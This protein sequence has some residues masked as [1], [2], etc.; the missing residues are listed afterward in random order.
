MVLLLLFYIEKPNVNNVNNRKVQ[1]KAQKESRI[2]E[3]PVNTFSKLTWAKIQ[4]ALCTTWSIFL[5]FGCFLSLLCLFST[6]FFHQ[7]FSSDFH[8]GGPVH[9]VHDCVITD[10]ILKEK[11]STKIV[12]ILEG[13]GK[14]SLILT[15]HVVHFCFF[16]ETRTLQRHWWR[17]WEWACE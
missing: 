5:L 1:Y 10:T 3:K 11:G 4:F 8:H 14:Y 6:P 7:I 9:A 17:R 13:C 15:R 2:I 12:I 16:P